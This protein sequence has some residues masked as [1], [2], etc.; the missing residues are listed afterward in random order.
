[1]AVT[2]VVVVGLFLSICCTLPCAMFIVS[3]IMLL[4]QRCACGRMDTPLG[5]FMMNVGG[6]FSFL[7]MIYLLTCISLVFQFMF[8]GGPKKSLIYVARDDDSEMIS[9][10][11]FA[12]ATF[13]GLF[14]IV[15]AF[16][17]LCRDSATP[18]RQRLAQV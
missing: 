14:S 6:A 1:M 3:I 11:L 12:I 10:I 13:I 17:Y 5:K 16:L 4:F 2:F 8:V 15:F 18:Y 9:V 7:V